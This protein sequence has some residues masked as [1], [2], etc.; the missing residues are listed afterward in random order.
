MIKIYQKFI[1]WYNYDKYIQ[2]RFIGYKFAECEP[3]SEHIDVTWDNLNHIY[4]EYGCYAPFITYNI[5]KTQVIE[6]FDANIINW[7]NPKELKA[8]YKKKNP[9]LNMYIKICYKEET[10]LS[11]KEIMEI[12]DVDN[13]IKYISERGLNLNNIKDQ[14]NK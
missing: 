3:E 5:F 14:L 1:S 11:L 9:Q 10:N 13:V 8:I 2:R 12:R 6:F 7:F 4:Y